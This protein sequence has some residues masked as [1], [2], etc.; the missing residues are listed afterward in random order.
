MESF[1]AWILMALEMRIWE[2]I[3]SEMAVDTRKSRMMLMSTSLISRTAY[4]LFP[5]EHFGGNGVD[6]DAPNQQDQQ[7]L[8]ATGQGSAF[9]G[10][11]SHGIIECREGQELDDGLQ[12]SR[13]G[14]FREKSAREEVLGEHEQ[15]GIDR[16]HVLVS[17]FAVVE[18]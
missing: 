11:F 2:G 17:V 5:P 3:I 12:E 9:E 15:V 8:P 1:R 14:R 10:H 13:Q 16:D 7:L 18:T 4:I 6:Q